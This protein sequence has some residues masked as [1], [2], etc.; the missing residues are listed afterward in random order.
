[1]RFKGI[2]RGNT[3]HKLSLYADDLLLY[4]T[5]TETSILS[6]LETLGSFG[7]LTGYKLNLSKNILFPI[8]QLAKELD[9]STFPL[10]IDLSSFSYLGIQVI[11]TFTDL[12]KQN[13]APVREN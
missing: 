11:A 2:T 1:M 9:Y 4:I 10:K 8:N 3:T 7:C 6:A 5:D 12:F 13:F